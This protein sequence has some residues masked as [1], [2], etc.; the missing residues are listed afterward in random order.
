M[1]TVEQQLAWPADFL[2]SRVHGQLKKEQP[3]FLAGLEQP[4]REAERQ[5]I[6]YIVEKAQLVWPLDQNQTPMAAGQTADCRGSWKKS[7]WHLLA[8]KY[9][10]VASQTADRLQLS[11]TAENSL[12]IAF[13]RSRVAYQSTISSLP[14]QLVNRKLAEAYKLSYSIYMEQLA[15]ADKN[16]L[17]RQLT[18]R[19]SRMQRTR[20]CSRRQLTT[21]N[22]LRISPIFRKGIPCCIPLSAS[23]HLYWAHV[24]QFCRFRLMDSFGKNVCNF[25]LGGKVLTLSLSHFYTKK[26][27]YT[28][29][30]CMIV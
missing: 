6:A 23:K 17:Q 11:Y 7:S 2:S 21:K 27:V 22:S 12:A 29:T 14:L 3:S 18:R 8:M 1:A 5:Q 15:A 30:Q 4:P 10:V 13:S 20:S 16:S 28:E 24:I 25:F 19:C 26:R 9:I